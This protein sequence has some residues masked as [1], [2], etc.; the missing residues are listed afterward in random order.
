MLTPTP[1]GELICSP[2]LLV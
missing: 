2:L 1:P